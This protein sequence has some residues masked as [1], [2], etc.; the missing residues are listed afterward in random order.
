LYKPG[1]AILDFPAGN[2]NGELPLKAQSS[3][4]NRF[5]PFAFSLQH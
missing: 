2:K 1:F 5:N 4:K 3:M